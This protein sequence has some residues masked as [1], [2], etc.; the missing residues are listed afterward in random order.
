MAEPSAP[1]SSDAPPATLVGRMPGDASPAIPGSGPRSA[2]MI[3]RARVPLL[4]AMGMVV[5]VAVGIPMWLGLP[6]L[7][8]AGLF[9]L[10]ALSAAV[11]AIDGH[12][13]SFRRLSH[14]VYFAALAA[15]AWAIFGLGL[16]PVISVYFPAIV[17]LGAAHIMGA[18]AAIF[19]AVPSI[20]L[21]AAAT[22]A[23]PAEV[24][25]VSPEIAF[26]VRAAT[27]VT[28]LAFAVSFRR[29]HDRQAA[30]LLRRA[31][32]DPLTGLA[33]RL[34]LGRAFD[35]AFERST[36]YG[37]TGALIFLDLDGLKGINDSLGH[38][39]GDELI[40]TTARRIAQNTRRIDTAARMGGDE[41][42]VL[43]SE[44]EDPKGAEVVARKLLAAV[45]APCEI[46]GHHV[47]PGA[48]LG[49]AL[50]PTGSEGPEDILRQADHAMY[51]SK[52][53]GGGRI[54]LRDTWALREVV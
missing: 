13:T 43:V 9:L 16:S 45:S 26:G 28:I 1:E 33:N 15:V 24:R 41:F 34:E 14:G 48:S 30:E 51:Q 29:A 3:G 50:F 7:S 18:R 37:R 27:L 11:R 39:V 20:A 52:R 5:L 19:W 10:F 46:G 25:V 4:T 36:R 2:V 31:T 32:T 35:T 6:S 23:A 12:A 38:I 21:I 17:L 22:F 53:A 47:T 40:C 42:V 8:L 44:L 49:V 54:Y